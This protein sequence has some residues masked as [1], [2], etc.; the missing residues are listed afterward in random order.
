MMLVEETSVPI[1][2][3]PVPELKA[4][5]RLGSGFAEDDLQNAVLESFLRAAMAAAEART[6]KILIEREF[7]WIL[8]DW[9]DAEAQA[10]PVAPIS[11]VSA[12]V[13]IDRMGVETMMSA[14]SYRLVQDSQH[15]LLCPVST[16]LPMVPTDG[17]VRIEMTAGYGAGWGDIPADLAQAVLM[18][19]AHYYE[20]RFDTAL[21]GGCMPFGV[22]SLLERY[23]PVR[24][25]A[26][27]LS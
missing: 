4:H 2:V 11:A 16:L 25:S 20:Y 21:S 8:G 13:L 10:L 7:S 22:T 14:S 24:I 19:A 27:S 23:R 18:L 5:L 26:G 6:G 12:V 1:A 17:T 9:R 3:L 15:P